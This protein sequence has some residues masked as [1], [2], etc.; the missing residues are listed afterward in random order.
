[1]VPV[2]LFNY[3]NLPM[4]L[5]PLYVRVHRAWRQLPAAGLWLAVLTLSAGAGPDPAN[6]EQEFAY[7]QLLL[8]SGVPDYAV[9]VAERL[10]L[11]HPELKDRG[12]VVR[13][14]ALIAAR[15]MGDAEQL[16]SQMPVGSPKTSAVQL[17]LADGYYQLGKAD[18]S[19]DIYR[20][21]F[22]RYGEKPP[23]DPDLRRF[24][25]EAAH[26]FAQMLN[27][28]GDLRGSAGVYG[29]LI[30]SLDDAEML[31]Q[32][33]LEQSELLLRSAR[34]TP[35]AP[36]VAGL[37]A[38][39]E[40]NC[41]EVIWGGMDLWFGRAVTCLAE[42]Q[43]QRGSRDEAMRTLH[44]NLQMLKKLDEALEK[45]DIPLS[46]SPFA[47]ARSLLG[48]LHVQEGDL[49]LA[50]AAAREAEALRNYALA[51]DEAEQVWTLL[52]SIHRRDQALVARGNVAKHLVYGTPEERLQPLRDMRALLGE[53]DQLLLTGADGGAWSA[54][55]A[56]ALAALKGRTEAL[57]AALTAYP[58]A[59]GLTPSAEI[60]LGETFEGRRQMQR[61]SGL[62]AA[63]AQRHDQA[64]TEN[65]N[66]LK[67]F[68]NVFAGYP[69]SHWSEEAG[70][71]VTLLKD[72]L[73]ALTGKEVTI[74]ATSGGQKRI[75]LVHMSE[76]HDLL[77]RKQYAK[78][79]E[80]YLKGLNAYPD[81][82]ESVVAL[83]GL[84]ESQAGLDDA[85]WVEM[86][87][88]YLAERFA[89][90]AQAA[91][92]LL[93]MGRR[94]FE[95]E[96]RDMFTMLYELYL[97]HFP[98]H[99]TAPTILFMLG[100]QRWKVKDYPGAVV[101]YERLAS[102]Y[103]DG[104]YSLKSLN[105]IA[106]SQYL[107]GDFAAAAE[108]FQTV[109]AQSP[110]GK[111]RAEAKL[112][113]A[114]S[115][116]Q[117]NRFADAVREYHELAKW[118]QEAGT[119]YTSADQR[120][121]FREILE[122][123]I[124]FQAYCLGRVD[125]PAE[126]AA[127]FRTAA[128]KL[129]Q[130][131]V[132]QFPGSSLAPTAL[133]SMGALLLVDGEAGKA[134]AAYTRLATDYPK[135]EAGRDAKFAMVRSLIDVGQEMKA[136]AAVEGMLRETPRPAAPDLVKIGLLLLDAGRGT[137]AAKALQLGLDGLDAAA[138]P[139]LDQRARIGLGAAYC[140]TGAY[141]EAVACLDGLI[142]TYPKSAFFYRARFL[143][144][145]A[146]R[147]LGRT[148]EATQVLRD[149]FERAADQHL[150]DEATVELARVQAGAGKTADALASCQRIVLLS[151]P[152]DPAGRNAYEEA[153]AL[154]VT[155]LVEREAWADAAQAV[156]TYEARF[157]SGRNRAEVLKL[158]TTIRINLPSGSNEETKRP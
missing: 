138:Q 58:A 110:P 151:D 29:L 111:P 123:A 84:L 13:A 140:D 144:G 81:G 36:D 141:E 117:Q 71:Q 34:Q 59:E 15:R 30:R 54:P 106:W 99:G 130:S 78:A 7:A 46:E 18:I 62:L 98:E 48:L 64:V 4:R 57:R 63:E 12:N 39:A 127:A 128:V 153:L 28:E 124:F 8:G 73:K 113:L 96:R 79:V 87:A 43:V 68:Y 131:F 66:A 157:K 89:G 139:V 118:L 142:Q 3:D 86:V 74:K 82:E 44:G 143:L 97:D 17:A 90:H 134:A 120:D 147:L 1:V 6:I 107:S 23:E 65:M 146:Y 94:Y 152:D 11:R 148:E 55:A 31:R 91:Q 70:E 121:T 47:G 19:A 56:A 25:S 27:Q 129:Y 16:L 88:R 61:G 119:I 116:R 114:D 20:S 77:A 150:I 92:G 10:V 136:E 69:G 50:P 2:W 35:G 24:Y 105:R 108:R 22:K 26:K 155:L 45:A 14:E 33:R 100:E 76:G 115:R 135:S 80:A 40:T 132:T 126:R 83:A 154:S 156:E 72:R 5:D 93:R 42:L 9:M 101:Y 75:G 133:S 32:A 137:V 104:G 49:M 51:L 125:Q 145:R 41:N 85:L 102:R 95:L 60:A 52:L 122:Q 67:Q 112:C 103:P 21:F 109:I 149:V 158:R 38:Q 37:L 53:F